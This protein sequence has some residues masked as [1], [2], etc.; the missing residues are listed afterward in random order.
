VRVASFTFCSLL[1]AFQS[2]CALFR[3]IK[4]FDWA[5]QAPVKYFK[6]LDGLRFLAAFAVIMGH[7]Q[8]TILQYQ[9][10]SPYAPFA[11]KLATFGVDFFF[12]LS[13]F[14]ISY[15]LM[16]EIHKT[17]TIN[18]RAF[19]YR[20]ILRIFP[21]YF[22]VGF[23]G[24]F[25]GDFWVK[26]FDFLTFYDGKYANYV[27]NS[28][29]FLKNLFFLCTFSINFQTLLG[30]QNPVSSL[31]VGHLWSLAVEEQF[32]LIWSPI[33]L[34]F[35]RHL[36][37]VIGVFLGLGFFFNQLPEAYFS[38]YYMFH[39]NFTINRFWYF[40]LGA[41]FAWFL[42]YF[43]ITML[44]DLLV[45]ALKKRK[46]DPSVFQTISA[47]KTLI[48]IVLG[49][50][51]FGLTLICN[52]LF[53]AIYYAANVYILNALIA[54][55]I[56]AVAVADCSVLSVLCLENKV[57]KY[58]G[59]ISYG[60]YMFHIFSIFMAYKLLKDSG[61]SEKSDTFYMLCPILATGLATGLA[62]LSYH[63]FEQTFLHKE[64]HTNK[65]SFSHRAL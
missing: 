32:Y 2:F 31:N 12:V 39:Y 41:A 50:Q 5:R 4:L 27:Y 40:G 7:C 3:A 62:A 47:P 16:Q 21:L 55:F 1:R 20:R 44:W 54:L 33:L 6:N 29:D 53:E 59:K 10:Y 35:K 13:G 9:G 34:V 26:Y 57:F 56:I 46:E 37:A 15:L 17:G 36:G 64:R 30:L 61:I 8:S 58:L 51:F 45:N 14:L 18:I 22:L 43:S 49:S 42:C 23:I 48:L 24:I 19:Y 63:F 52:Y 11:N 38:Q 28:T 60:I 65:V 25:A